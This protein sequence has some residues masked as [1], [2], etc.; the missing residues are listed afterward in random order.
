MINSNIRNSEVSPNKRNVLVDYV[1]RLVHLAKF[2]ISNKYHL[3]RDRVNYEGELV[4]LS[5]LVSIG[6]YYFFRA[7]MQEQFSVPRASSKELL[8]RLIKLARQDARRWNL[9]PKRIEEAVQVE[10]GN[11]PYLCLYEPPKPQHTLQSA[12]ETK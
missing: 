2:A 4:R 11:L 7:P 8:E 1:D 5:K 12:G 6:G 3:F 9:R 10:D